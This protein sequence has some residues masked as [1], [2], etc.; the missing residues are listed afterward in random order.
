M[1]DWSVSGTCIEACSSATDC[2]GDQSCVD[3]CDEWECSTSLRECLDPLGAGEQCRD[4]EC[5]ADLVCAKNWEG[6]QFGQCQP[7]CQI[8]EDCGVDEICAGPDRHGYQYPLDLNTCIPAAGQGEGCRDGDCTSNLVCAK[9]NTQDDWGTCT[10]SCDTEA[11]CEAGSVCLSATVQ[12]YQ[13]PSFNL[14]AAPAG[15]SEGCVDGQCA[16]GLVCAKWSAQDD[17]G[18]CKVSCDTEADCASGDICLTANLQGYQSPVFNT[19]A[20]PSGLYS[21]CIQDQCASDL[22][23]AKSWSG[24]EFGS[25]QSVC[26]TAADCSAGDVCVDAGTLEHNYSV[27]STCAPPADLHQS[28]SAGQCRAGLSCTQWDTN[29]DSLGTCLEDCSSSGVCTGMACAG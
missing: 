4:G 13:S 22:V 3:F 7:L 15:E 26:D 18:T 1:N 10:A 5:S 19:C 27:F 17:W 23:C 11:D 2:L 12:G 28:C 9:W 29:P 6:D 20:P 21:M 16:D 8:R 14:C 24:A 25:C